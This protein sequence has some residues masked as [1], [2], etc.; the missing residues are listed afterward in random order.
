MNT[1]LCDVS[2][3]TTLAE[4]SLTGTDDVISKATR[5]LVETVCF[6]A[7]TSLICVISVPA[8]VINC[9]VFCRQGLQERMNVCLFCLALVDCFYL[10]CVFTVY[11]VSVFLRFYDQVLSEEY[12]SKVFVYFGGALY[13]FR[14]LSHCITMVIA[15]ERCVC[16]VYPLQAANLLQ[17]RSMGYLILSGFLLFHGCY[18]LLPFSY[19]VVKIVVNEKVEWKFF[20]TPFFEN[21]RLI[22]YTLIYTVLGTVLPIVAL[23]TVCLTTFIT[24]V[25]L[26]AAMLWRQRTSLMIN[27]SHSQQVALTKMLVIVSCAYILTVAPL[28]A[29]QTSFW[30]VGRCLSTGTCYNLFMALSAVV[31]TISYLNSC[32]NIVIY[33]S[34]SSRFRVVLV[35]LF[36]S[37]RGKA[38]ASVKSVGRMSHMT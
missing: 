36:Y 1:S 26:R 3:T 19:H 6:A 34:R 28:V 16:V 17:A 9:L 13:G 4:P 5:E 18:L 29:W 22:V 35:S 37:H 38:P 31:F 12:S 32:F 21:N 25:K 33:Y 30:F 8:N 2:D 23:L 24:V 10:T 7:L 14:T 20:P 15:L 27:E 11:S